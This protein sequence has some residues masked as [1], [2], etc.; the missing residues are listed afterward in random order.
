MNEE[1][2]AEGMREK[3]G[4]RKRKRE[5]RRKASTIFDLEIISNTYEVD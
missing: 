5:R 1:R 2:K 3:D 4:Q